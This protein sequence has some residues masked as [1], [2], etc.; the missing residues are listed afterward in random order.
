MRKISS[1][2]FIHIMTTIFIFYTSNAFSSDQKHDSTPWGSKT[3]VQTKR[4]SL[5]LEV[6]PFATNGTVKDLRISGTALKPRANDVDYIATAGGGCF[7]VSGG[8]SSQVFNTPVYLPER[9]TVHTLRMYYDD[10]SSS[11]NSRAWFSVYDLYGDLVEEWSLDS[12]G[13]AGNGFN[14]SATINH[15]I[16]YSTYSYMINWRAY[17]DGS[18]TQL[19][20]FRIFYTPPPGRTVMFPIGVPR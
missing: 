4:E 5:E 19:C 11:T 15:I 18:D 20:G 17:D 1:S 12:V 3:E 2:L 13:S 7:Y 6:S 10:T 9:T 14:D 16:D 8:N